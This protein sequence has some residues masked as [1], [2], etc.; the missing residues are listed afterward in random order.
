MNISSI[1][2]VIAPAE[3]AAY[4]ASKFA[5][6]G[7]SEALRHELGGS[8]VGVTVVHP[9]GVKTAIAASARM[10]PEDAAE[11]AGARDREASTPPVDRSRCPLRRP[12][13][14]PDARAVLVSAP[15]QVRAVPDQAH[16]SPKDAYVAV[17]PGTTY[18]ELSSSRTAPGLFYSNCPTPLLDVHSFDYVIVGAGSAGCVLANRL[19]ERGAHRVLL[20]EAGGEDKDRNI[21]IPAAF[22]KLYEGPSDWNYR[23]E[24]QHHL[25]G[26][27]LYQPRGKMLGGSSSMN[28][29]IYIRGHR[30]D[31]DHWAALG[32]DGWSYEDVLPYFKRSEDQQRFRD[33]PEHGTGGPLVVC[34]QR[35]P[36]PLSAA[37]VEAAVE[38]GYPRNHDFNSGDQ[39]GF[40]YYQ[41]TQRDGRR[42]S[43]ARAF[44]LPARKRK[45]LEVW[46]GATAHRIIVENGR[47]VG[48]Q[49][50]R[51][52]VV[53]TVRATREVILAAGAFG[54]PHLLML[55]GIGPAE[56]LRGQGVEVVLDHPGV[57][58]NLQDHLITGVARRSS[59]GD[60]LDVAEALTRVGRNLF[61]YFLRKTGPFTSNVAEAGGFA[62][63]SPA[64]DAPDVQYHFGPGFFLEHGRRNPKNEPGYTLGG[65]VLTPES[66][67][68]V[69]LKSADPREKPLVDPRYLSDPTGADLRRTIWGFRLAQRIADSEAFAP[70][71]DGPYEPE[72]VLRS[73]EEIVPF[74]RAHSETLYH[75]VGTCRMGTDDLAVVDPRLRVH[76]LAGLRVVDA[77]VMPTITRGNTNAPTIMIAEK[78]A[79]FI[80]Q[81]TPVPI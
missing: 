9:S 51:D 45:N 6:R 71:N 25:N 56:H 75:P 11:T 44:L 4:V 62:R 38:Q 36:N 18:R 66:R 41:V 12:I 39:E 46:T 47:A 54:S 49:T 7:F 76:G 59:Y 10:A 40:G 34:D 33:D 32:C 61:N 55:S 14:A 43:V 70:F 16:L 35:S 30:A 74:I 19:T 68:T 77:S 23:T 57:G 37:L 42:W 64:L 21:H 50:E 67:G 27:R 8:P 80:R 73:D 28:A 20:L 78:A 13:A 52:G 17:A 72:R 24:P 60:T 79:D 31:Y 22:Y 1:F 65:L 15:A 58:E 69:R 29:M 63:S 81:S 26:R 2:G 3:Q 48:V 53:Q 5:V